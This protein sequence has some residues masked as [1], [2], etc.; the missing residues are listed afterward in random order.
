MNPNQKLYE[1]EVRHQVG[2]RRYSAATLRKADAL[3][4]RLGADLARRIRNLV[5]TGEPNAAGLEALNR[6]LLEWTN[7]R[8]E[9]IDALEALLSGD[10]E[11]LA[12]Y[13]RDFNTAS[14]R[15]VTAGVG[16]NVA[17]DAAVVAA[18]NSRPFQG[19][20][21]REWMQGLDASIAAQVRDQLRIGYLEGEGIN[22][23]VRRIRGTRARKY[24]D[25]I[26]AVSRRA[27]Q[28]VV[29]TA[30]THTANAA[31]QE[32]YKAASETIK[33]VRYVAILD[34]RTSLICAGLDGEE[35]PI[36]KGPRPPQHPN[37]RSTTAAV[38]KGA[39]SFS[40]ETYQAWLERQPT[41]VQNEILGPSRAKLFREGVAVD[42]F[43]DRNG[44]V[45]DLDELKQRESGV[46]MRAGLDE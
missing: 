28:R 26:L 10:M 23:L 32:T 44:Q 25:G 2:L 24:E 13:E 45:W 11:A 37:C 30:M 35:F 12:I 40:R 27:A 22:A 14:L 21:L 39:P 33:A 18:V 16:L 9:V 5:L 41:D 3:L 6:L 42:R 43:T 19:R 7:K 46:W 15:S 36:D 17:T 1:R 8:I 29:R 31:S 20:F 4:A 38:I 34:G